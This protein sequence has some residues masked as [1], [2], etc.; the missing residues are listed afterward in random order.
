MTD[1]HP[2]QRD[3]LL[4][5]LR[6]VQRDRQENMSR[7]VDCGHRHGYPHRPDCPFVKLVARKIAL[8]GEAAKLEIEQVEL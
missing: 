2:A 5:H 8:Y 6:A 4:K 3:Y 7:C 1:T